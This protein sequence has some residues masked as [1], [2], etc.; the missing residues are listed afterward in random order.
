VP[1]L[2]DLVK[3]YIH[4]ASEYMATHV[5]GVVWSHYP[6]VDLKRLETDVSN[7]TDQRKANQL[8]ITSMETA[9][10]IIT[11]VDLCG[12]TRQSSQ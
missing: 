12:E 10:K 1:E 9:L 5:I 4:G 3:Q 6:R 8:R 2:L 7:N 11:D